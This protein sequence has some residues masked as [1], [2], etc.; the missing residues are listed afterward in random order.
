[1]IAISETVES[2]K[3]LYAKEKN[4]DLESVNAILLL[5]FLKKSIFII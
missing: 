4:K 2:Y 1:M 3:E 5:L